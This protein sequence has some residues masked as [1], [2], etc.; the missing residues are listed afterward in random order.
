MMILAVERGEK[1]TLVQFK[2]PN[3]IVRCNELPV[4]CEGNIFACLKL[5]TEILHDRL[6]R[7]FIEYLFLLLERK[8]KKQTTKKKRMDLLSLSVN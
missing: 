3:D 8:I 1:T 2:Y 4:L 6:I 7:L 5:L